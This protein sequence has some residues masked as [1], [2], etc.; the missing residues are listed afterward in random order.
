MCKFVALSSDD[1]FKGILNM[2]NYKALQIIRTFTKEEMG[3][4]GKFIASP[5]FSTGRDLVPLFTYLKK[6]HPE[7]KNEKALELDAVHKE[8]NVKG[9][10]SGQDT[11]RKLLSDLYKQT[12]DFLII[13]NFSTISRQRKVLLL[14]ELRGKKIYRLYDSVLVNL[15]KEYDIEGKAELDFFYDLGTF[16]AEKCFYFNQ[17]AD[18]E[19]YFS[20]FIKWMDS[21][22]TVSL[23]TMFEGLPNV[24]VV[25]TFYGLKTPF[26]LLTALNKEINFEELLETLRTNNYKFY[27]IIALH[28]YISKAH[29][30]EDTDKYYQLSSELFFKSYGLYNRLQLQGLFLNLQAICLDNLD[31]LKNAYYDD[32]V[33][34]YRFIFDN[35]ILFNTKEEYIPLQLFKNIISRSRKDLIDWTDKFVSDNLLKLEPDARNAMKNFW[36][37]QKCILKSSYSEALNYIHKIDLNNYMLKMEIKLLYLIVYYELGHLEEARAMIDTFTKYLKQNAEVSKKFRDGTLSFLA[38]YVKL[39]KMKE[40]RHTEKME[41]VLGE[42]KISKLITKRDWLQEKAA[43]LE[44]SLKL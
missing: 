34:L 27:E 33:K 18:M 23:L 8:L 19:N 9:K 17:R 21:V 14:K 20:S 26:N 29:T 39:L 31:K 16:E 3:E 10:K 30:S 13:R 2:A 41:E 12:E 42:L 37:A 32:L 22:L 1:N 44:R 11:T 4:F 5:Y 36:S 38:I 24:N 6:Y 35:N 28:Y 40:S 15:E 43:E 25:E 7:Y